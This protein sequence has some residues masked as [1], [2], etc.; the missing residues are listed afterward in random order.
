M[1]NIK[2]LYSLH[3]TYACVHV[4]VHSKEYPLRSKELEK[5]KSSDFELRNHILDSVMLS[6]EPLPVDI[7]WEVATDGA[8]RPIC[9]GK[10]SHLH[11]HHADATYLS[12]NTVY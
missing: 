8:L 4:F 2:S 1:E 12:F 5:L 11:F 10:K 9:G 6:I 3:H 7:A